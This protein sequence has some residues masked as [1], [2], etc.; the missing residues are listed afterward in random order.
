MAHRPSSR[1][2]KSPRA[3]GDDERVAGEYDGDVVVPTGETPALV[4]VE[5]EFTFEILIGALDLPAVVLR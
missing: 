4:V 3:F 5:A 2:G 1:G